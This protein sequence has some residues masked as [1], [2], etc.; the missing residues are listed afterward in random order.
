[1]Q[2]H[3]IEHRQGDGEGACFAVQLFKPLPESA[4]GPCGVPLLD[5]SEIRSAPCYFRQVC[6]EHDQFAS[7]NLIFPGTRE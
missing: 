2:W 6:G 1:M 4:V 5:I 3:S 7:G